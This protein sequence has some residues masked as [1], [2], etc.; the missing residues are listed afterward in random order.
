MIDHPMQTGNDKETR[1][2]TCISLPMQA[3]DDATSDQMTNVSEFGKLLIQH[4]G[5][6]KHD[7]EKVLNTHHGCA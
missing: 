1:K 5:L 2:T 6:D 7:C 3:N 4:L